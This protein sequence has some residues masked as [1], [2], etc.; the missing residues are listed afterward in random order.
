M[1][2]GLGK[3]PIHVV[4]NNNIY[5]YIQIHE[6]QARHLDQ[7]ELKHIEICGAPKFAGTLAM[8]KYMEL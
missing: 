6:F 8:G 2:G 1:A 7:N 3:S 4:Y 5:R